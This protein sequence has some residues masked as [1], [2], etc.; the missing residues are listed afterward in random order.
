M[1]LGRS[2]EHSIEKCGGW[3]KQVLHLTIPVRANDGQWAQQY[4]SVQSADYLF[5]L[6]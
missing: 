3:S 2:V 4:E 6:T 5:R 1:I